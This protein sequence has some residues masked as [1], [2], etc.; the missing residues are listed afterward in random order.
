MA[1]LAQGEWRSIA[2]R[3]PPPPLIILLRHGQ[4]EHHVRG[5]SGGWTQTP[6]TALGHEQSER[7]AAR[8][9]AELGE[10][11]VRLF[12]SDL[13]R[14]QETARHI[15]AAFGVEAVPDA[16][17]REH[18]NGAAVD[19]TMTE[20]RERFPGVFDSPWPL[21]FRPFPGSETGR[22]FYE[23]AG[24]FI[25]T[26]PDK[27][28][29]PVVVSHGGTLICLVARWLG[30]TPEALEPVGFAFHTAS[31]TVLQTDR[32]GSRIVERLNDIA[33]VAGLDGWVGLGHLVR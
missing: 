5:L 20:V 32:H 22:E 1:C 6:L 2:S 12:T 19:L 30:L 3:M 18:N 23:R 14:C 13:L 29:L 17:L 15:A 10:I 8:L 26:L 7:A 11:P 31:I 4:S 16:R 27:G 21:D 25:D 24:A 9:K 33:H 28:P